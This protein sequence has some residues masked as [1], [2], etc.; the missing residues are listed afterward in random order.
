MGIRINLWA[1]GKYLLNRKNTVSIFFFTEKENNS[2]NQAG[3]W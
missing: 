3:K 1:L 2:Q